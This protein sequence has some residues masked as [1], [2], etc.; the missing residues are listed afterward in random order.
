[1]IDTFPRRH[2][3][4]VLLQLSK[5]KFHLSVLLA[6]FF[7]KKPF[8]ARI[9]LERQMGDKRSLQVPNSALP[10]VTD[11]H[12]RLL[13]LA[14]LFKALAI[15][16]QCFPTPGSRV[17]PEKG[18]TRMHCNGCDVD[19]LFPLESWRHVPERICS[20]VE[21]SESQT[22]TTT[23]QRKQQSHKEQN[24][25]QVLVPFLPRDSDCAMGSHILCSHICDLI[26]MLSCA[27]SH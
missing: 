8:S 7:L 4:T 15:W 16:H 3:Q 23:W 19:N 12:V 9:L 27:C 20:Q 10:D 11:V 2:K 24:E 14:A 1:M 22:E 17:W 18:V 26:C 25:N 6:W 13:K 21:D 5:Q